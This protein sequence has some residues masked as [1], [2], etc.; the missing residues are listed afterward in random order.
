ML[1]QFIVF[2]IENAS[3]HPCVVYQELDFLYL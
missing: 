1:V 3:T 2:P